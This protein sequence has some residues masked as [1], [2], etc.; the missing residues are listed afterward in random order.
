MLLQ[1]PGGE[2]LGGGTSE[3]TEVNGGVR[4]VGGGGKQSCRHQRTIWELGK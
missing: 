1:G 2:N 4:L 3:G